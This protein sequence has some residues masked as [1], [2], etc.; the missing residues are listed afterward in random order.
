M[1]PVVEVIEIDGD[2]I[3]SRL[4]TRTTTKTTTKKE[5]TSMGLEP[6]PRRTSALSWR[7]RPLSHKAR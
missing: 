5:V 3:P 2:M 4:P 6:M 7:I 1:A